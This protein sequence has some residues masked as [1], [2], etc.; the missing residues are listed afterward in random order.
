M[1][2]RRLFRFIGGKAHHVERV[3]PLIAAHLAKTNGKLISPFYGSGAIER[4]TCLPPA[5]QIAAEA[6]TELRWALNTMRD[7]PSDAVSWALRDM[8]HLAGYSRRSY[9]RVQ[10]MQVGPQNLPLRAARFLYLQ[11]FA[12]N[13]LWRVNKQGEHNVP[14]DPSR[15]RRGAGALPS[16]EEISSFAER[17]PAKIHVDWRNVV[18]VAIAGDVLIVDP[19]YLDGFV[20]YTAEG[21]SAAEQGHLAD[22]LHLAVMRGAAVIAFN[23]PAARALYPWAAIEEVQRSGR[24]SSKGSG[25]QPVSELIISCGLRGAQERA[26]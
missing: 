3:A 4:A 11:S 25:R 7:D 26:A 6:A 13:G 15:L 22:A 10:T 1:K 24:M 5:R 17:L 19:P 14:P 23:A 16:M 20:A 21:F 9:R 8:A 18:E 2:E 12:F